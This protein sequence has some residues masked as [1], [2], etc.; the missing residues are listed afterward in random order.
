[1]TKDQANEI[2]VGIVVLFCLAL[3]LVVAMKLSNWQSWV[4]PQKTITFRVP[5]QAGIG[6]IKAGWPVVIG[7]VQVGSVQETWLKCQ[8]MDPLHRPEAP[9]SEQPETPVAKDDEPCLEKMDNHQE[10]RTYSY[11]KFTIP[12]KYQLRED[13]TLKPLGQLIGG[14]GEL[15]IIDMGAGELLQDG[16]EVYRDNLGESMMDNVELVMDKAKAVMDKTKAAVD[17]LQKVLDKAKASMDNVETI[18]ENFKD[19]SA[20]ARETMDM[21]KPKVES[22]LDRASASMDNVKN[23]TEDLKDASGKTRDTVSL[24]KPQIERIIANLRETSEEMKRGMR[25]IRWN[26]WRLLHDPTDRELRTQ[27]LLTSARA[28]SSGASDL[29]AAAGRLQGLIDA[30]QGQVATDDPELA[31]IIE[32][33]Q[34]TMEKFNEA[35]K[36]FFK[37]LGKGN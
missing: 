27:N 35:E 34:A 26:P 1:M 30:R 17:D 28:F 13:C 18:T 9:P 20:K 15:L 33:L 25:E 37:R 36:A 22:I 2:K 23:I 11:F 19:T 16:Q 5:Y 4:E 12:S 29:D 6:G 10:A 24:T 21:T 8:E 7:G 3:G 14:A 32:E 31:K